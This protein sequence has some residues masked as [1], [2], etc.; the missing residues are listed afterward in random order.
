M[1]GALYSPLFGAC[2]SC[3]ELIGSPAT[4]ESPHKFSGAWITGKPN[5][6]LASELSSLWVSITGK[7]GFLDTPFCDSGAS[8]KGIA[9]YFISH[10]VN[11]GGFIIGRPPPNLLLSSD[12]S[13]TSVD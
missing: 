13:D 1:A 9:L 7:P 10:V 6:I 11:Y 8:V 12:A 4:L 2:V 3:T 5:T